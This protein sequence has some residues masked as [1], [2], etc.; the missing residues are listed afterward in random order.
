MASPSA[1][2]QPSSG[3]LLAYLRLF[4]LPNVFTALAD[5][6]MGFLYVRH[7]LD[8][9]LV[10]AALLGASALLY[11]SGM[12]LN[13]VFDYQ[14]DAQQRPFR[15][16]PSG[17][18]SRRWACWLGCEML[19]IGV[20]LA[21]LAG[22]IQPSEVAL[23]WRSGVVA[24]ALAGLIL[25]YNG[26]CKQTWL[27][28]WVMGSCRTANVL[29]AMSVCGHLRG[30]MITLGFAADELLVAGGIGL[31]IAGVTSFARLEASTSNRRSLAV[32]LVWMVS[33]IV[34]L[35]VHPYWHTAGGQ[36]PADSVGMFQL[37]L[38]V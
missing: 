8:P 11:T 15:P 1:A 16:L 5:I 4:R 22:V 20:L 35:G 26:V 33:G 9:P 23:P 10:F 25:L 29:M 32:A 31:Y 37:L 6:T 13:D 24:L 2:Q 18:I 36:Q 3:L 34:V 30:G 12:V 38:L 28:P 19:L 21:A 7:A 27:G 17:R 14:I